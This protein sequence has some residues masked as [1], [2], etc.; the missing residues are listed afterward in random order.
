MLV[1]HL[2]RKGEAVCA[3]SLGNKTPCCGGGKIILKD[4][5]IFLFFVYEKSCLLSQ[6]LE[7]EIPSCCVFNKKGGVKKPVNLLVG[8]DFFSGWVFGGELGNVPHS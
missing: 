7:A 3:F 4:P 5:R 6:Y 2:W 1:G 8:A